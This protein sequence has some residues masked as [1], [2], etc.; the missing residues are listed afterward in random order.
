[1]TH[2]HSLAGL[3][4]NSRG[5]QQRLSQTGIKAKPRREQKLIAKEESAFQRRGEVSGRCFAFWLVSFMSFGV[6]NNDHSFSAF[7]FAQKKLQRKA[8]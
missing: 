8:N 6:Q 4:G 2:K 1:M 5:N 3:I 7:C